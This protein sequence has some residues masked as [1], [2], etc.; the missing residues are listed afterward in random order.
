MEKSE[1][2][3]IEKRKEEEKL[4][5]LFLSVSLTLCRFT[6]LS[7]RVSAVFCDYENFMEILARCVELKLLENKFHEGLNVCSL[8][9]LHSFHFILFLLRKKAVHG[10]TCNLKVRG[11]VLD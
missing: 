7:C 10:K 4:P 11:N 5:T 8:G 2:V 9:C 6:E 1:S 3:K